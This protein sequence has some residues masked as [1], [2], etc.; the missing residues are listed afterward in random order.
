MT[1]KFLI[2][3]IA[4]VAMVDKHEYPEKTTRFSHT[5][6]HNELI[7][8]FSGK[9]KVYFGDNV[10]DIVPDTIRFLPEGKT[11]RY[12]VEREE[13][14]MCIFVAFSA[15]QT[16]SENA[17]IL[18]NQYT[19]KFAPL[20]KKMFSVW[21]AKNDGYYFECI[22]ILYKIFAEMQKENYLPEKQYKLIKPAVDYINENF[23]SNNISMDKLA[24]L[25]GISYSYFK[26]IFVK[27]FSMTPKKYIINLKINNACELLKTETYTVSQISLM[28][29]F[30]DIYFF[31]RQFKEYM[32]ISP[33]IFIEKYKSSK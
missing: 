9:S 25:C 4:R 24:E 10:F 12:D 17:F 13:H 31:S 16:I 15:D 26:K 7:F 3:D 11:K 29:G 14:G 5:L 28:C 33:R 8:H 2:T 22:S 1:T 21:V 23:L 30:S 27:K 32:G 20:F 6:K 19:H 18:H